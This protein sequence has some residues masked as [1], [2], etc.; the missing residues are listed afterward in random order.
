VTFTYEG[1]DKVGQGGTVTLLVDGKQVGSGRID[2]TTPFKYSLS[3]NQDVGTDSGTPVTYDCQTPFD[4]EG[5]LEEV[6]IEIKV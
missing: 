6:T 5:K 4:F 3:E 2:K 1:G